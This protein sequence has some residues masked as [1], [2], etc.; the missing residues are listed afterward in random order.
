MA[1]EKQKR[2]RLLT[3]WLFASVL[4]VFAAVTAYIYVWIS[5]L[6]GTIWMAIKG[7]LPITLVI[8]VVA[9]ILYVLY[10]FLVYKKG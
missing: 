1:E 4:I 8:A 5:P 3:Y 9:V 6:T 7:A 10:Y 2:L